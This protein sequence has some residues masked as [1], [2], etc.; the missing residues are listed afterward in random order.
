MGVLFS[1]VDYEDLYR[2]KLSSNPIILNDLAYMSTKDRDTIR[3][4]IS[5]R[6]STKSPTGDLINN[7]PQ[8]GCG[9]LEGKNNLGFLCREETG[10]C[11]ERV[12]L[13][14]NK[15]IEPILWIRA[16]IGVSKLISPHIWKMLGQEFTVNNYN[17]I[18]WIANRNYRPSNV[19]PPAAFLA[20]LERAGIQRGYNY[21][22]NNFDQI[23]DTLYNSSKFK[24][25]RKRAGS[26][27]TSFEQLIRKNRHL[28]FTD[29]LP[30]INKLL[31]VFEETHM[32][33]YYEKSSRNLIDA[34]WT[35]AGI[36]RR[37][38]ASSREKKNQ[39]RVVSY[40]ELMSSKKEEEADELVVAPINVRT[41]ENATIRTIN[42]LSEYFFDYSHDV[43]AQKEGAMRHNAISCRADFSARAVITS[44]TNRHRY[45]EIHI[46]WSIGLTIFHLHIANHLRKRNETHGEQ[47]SSKKIT[48]FLHAHIYKYD[49]L[50]DEIMREIISSC[51]GGKGFPALLQRN[52]SLERGS[53]QNVFITFVNPNPSITV[54][55]NSILSVVG[56]NADKILS[57]LLEIIIQSF[58]NC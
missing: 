17:I 27:G 34:I 23:I 21:F 16:P 36:D 48:A 31:V 5:T 29:Y 14:I 38:R 53:I 46:P 15:N 35:L 47:W 41:N 3:S 55:Q 2:R 51:R 43:I 24:A 4:L 45:D 56:Y 49:E 28:I 33:T 26:K 1:L 54:I 42:T 32:G 22:V 9:K 8:C 6:Y 50:L 11:G 37:T 25:E 57:C 44:L 12:E 30:I 18:H 7:I 40:N 39:V 58:F 10:G 20:E 52:P 19:V 13:T